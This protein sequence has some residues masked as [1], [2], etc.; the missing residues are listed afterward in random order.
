MTATRREGRA[1][2][3]GA[4]IPSLAFDMTLTPGDF[5]ID[6]NGVWRADAFTGP[7]RRYSGAFRTCA[8][9]SQTWNADRT[10]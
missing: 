5:V 2:C 7:A 10:G 3:H 6:A 1:D 8:A 4:P 9:A